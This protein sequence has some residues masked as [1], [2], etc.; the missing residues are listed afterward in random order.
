MSEIIPYLFHNAPRYEESQ[1]YFNHDNLHALR[2]EIAPIIDC[3]EESL[4]I[5]CKTCVDIDLL[6]ITRLASAS[7]Q[8]F[9]PNQIGIKLIHRTNPVSLV[10]FL[11]LRFVREV[12]VSFLNA[13]FAKKDLW[14]PFSSTEKG[15]LAF[16]CSQV[17][18]DIEK[19][20]PSL[21]NGV[22]ID[23]IFSAKEAHG[24][25][26]DH[27]QISF[28]LAF[29]H[30]YHQF[31]GQIL[32][33]RFQTLSNDAQVSARHLLSV[34]NHVIS[35]L[36]VVLKQCRI[37][38]PVL[39]DLGIGDVIFF[40][41]CSLKIVNKGL[42]GKIYARFEHLLLWVDII[43]EQGTYFARMDNFTTE[44]EVN[45]KSI[46]I[47]EEM[48]VAD[49]EDPDYQTELNHHL[50]SAVKVPVSVEIASVPLSLK[51]ICQL[52]KDDIIDLNRKITDPLNL[53][54]D[55]KVIGQAMPIQIGDRLGIKITMIN[56]YEN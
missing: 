10:I 49:R 52:K 5:L 2:N 35:P 11:P 28:D 41:S 19:S 13:E 22:F 26:D 51:K 30:K 47:A 8:P 39:A 53:V 24:L 40:D 29:S 21:V 46:D 37:P 31:F 43:H 17:L 20:N 9:D 27:Y 1:L 36:N 55:K 33:P 50:A 48:D 6:Q 42:I 25:I 54:I 23:N 44:E 12:I 18:F 7:L 14:V 56:A 4:S 38:W 45:M 3:I 34:A 16:I 32:S 15:I